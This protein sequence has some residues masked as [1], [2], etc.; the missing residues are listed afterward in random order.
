M[1]A[2][3]RERLKS[4]PRR[5]RDPGRLTREIQITAEGWLAPCGSVEIAASIGAWFKASGW[6]G[7]GAS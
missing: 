1:R 2:K 5:H 3:T 7:G 4:T 6:V